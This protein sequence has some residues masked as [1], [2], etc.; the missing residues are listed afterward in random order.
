MNTSD[1]IALS[2]MIVVAATIVCLML[3]IAFH[4]DYRLTAGATAVGLIAAMV[5]LWPAWELV[6]R[7]VT[8][9]LLI[10][11]YALLFTGLLLLTG[12]VVTLLATGYWARQGSQREEFYLLLLLATLGTMVLAS[13]VHFASFFLGL[14]ILSVSLYTLIAYPRQATSTQAGLKYLILAAVS[15]SILLFGMALV[16]ADRGTMALDQL[17]AAPDGGLLWLAGLSLILVGI[18]FKLAIVPFHM[19]IADVYAGAPAPTAMFVAT[20]SKAAVFA[21]LLRFFLV[22]SQPEAQAPYGIIAAISILSM[23]GGSLLVLVQR[24]V[25]RLLGYSSIAHIGYALVALLVGGTAAA[26]SVTFYLAAYT[27]TLLAAFGVIILLGDPTRDADALSDYQ[28]VFWR[29]PGLAVV[30]TVALFSLAGIPLTAGFFGKFLLLMAGVGAAEWLLAVV[31]VVSSGI[32]L[33]AYLR[34]VVVM[35]RATATPE[36][37]RINRQAMGGAVLATLLLLLLWIGI[38]PKPLLSFLQTSLGG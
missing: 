37:V 33:F 17:A 15:A 25:K 5:T 8:S 30:L 19:W 23:L 22:L 2:P 32:S 31:L 1:M 9:L 4:R 12:L 10:D 3:I 26:I 16:Y 20:A 13:A 7:P 38:Y 11:Q 34:W 28:G 21:V 35:F 24:N 27:L 29:K 14:E 36:V 18:G 6:P